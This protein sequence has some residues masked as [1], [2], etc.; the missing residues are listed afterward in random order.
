MDLSLSESTEMENK[1]DVLK[2]T[3]EWISSWNSHDLEDILSHY[4][5]DVEITSPM[6][7]L[8]TGV[9]AESLAQIF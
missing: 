8:T 2:F 1:I 6:T 9:N 3:N 4:S 5:E 7:K